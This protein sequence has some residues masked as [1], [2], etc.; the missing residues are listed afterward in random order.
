ML[1][2]RKNEVLKHRVKIEFSSGKKNVRID[3]PI[4]I[5]AM[6]EAWSGALH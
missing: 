1:W 3:L 5:L 2:N 4:K 6:E